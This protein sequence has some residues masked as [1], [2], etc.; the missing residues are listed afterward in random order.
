[1]LS[2]T[3]RLSPAQSNPKI[4]NFFR[5]RSTD[6]SL[7]K[8]SVTCIVNDLDDGQILGCFALAHK[9]VL[10]PSSGMSITS[11]RKP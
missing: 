3:Y 8:L 5:N 9:A 1:M 6:F 2:L 7:R 11:R 10:I 4:E